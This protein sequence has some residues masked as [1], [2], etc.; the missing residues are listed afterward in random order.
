MFDF[1]MAYQM[2][3]IRQ[4]FGPGNFITYFP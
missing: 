2:S 3:P 4:L 1:Q